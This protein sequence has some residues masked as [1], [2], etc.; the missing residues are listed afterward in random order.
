MLDKIKQ[1]FG[2]NMPLI[3]KGIGGK[4]SISANIKT[5]WLAS[6]IKED[7]VELNAIRHFLRTKDKELFKD[8]VDRGIIL[9]FAQ[10]KNII[11]TVGRQVLAERLA[12]G[13]TY[14]G[15]I[16]Y[17]ALGT[18]TATPLNTDTVL[19]T[20][21]FRKIAASQTFDENIVYIDFFFTAPEI[22]GTF[23]EFGNFIDGSPA[24]DT[25]QL[26]SHILTGGWVKSFSE[27]LFV[28]CQ[29]TIN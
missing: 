16:N 25:G 10:T 19:D 5:F 27:S 15:E 7:S 1:F 21:V 24:V 20:E 14:T 9:N 26:F 17:G 28:S 12:G 3:Q 23:E 18:G 13:I 29:Y 4:V 8:L 11:V 2:G 6:W 22:A